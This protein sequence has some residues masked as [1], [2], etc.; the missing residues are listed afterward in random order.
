M[1]VTASMQ[2]TPA[3]DLETID[4]NETPFSHRNSLLNVESSVSL[5]VGQ[6]PLWRVRINETRGLHRSSPLGFQIASTLVTL[7]SRRPQ[8][9]SYRR[10]RGRGIL[11]QG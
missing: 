3:S 4:V 10:H 9:L 1:M 2:T 6:C 7:Y 5:V 11:I 8:R